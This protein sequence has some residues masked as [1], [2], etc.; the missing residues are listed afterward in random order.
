MNKTKKL[1]DNK[2]SLANKEILKEESRNY[3]KKSP[4]GDKSPEK[5]K[6]NAF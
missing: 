6:K 2:L 4:N 3:K 1:K 5:E